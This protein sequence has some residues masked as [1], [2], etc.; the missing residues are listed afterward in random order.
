[1]DRIN[2]TPAYI[3]LGWALLLLSL[4]PMGSQFK[5]PT[6]ISGFWPELVIGELILVTLC[7][8]SM[9][10]TRKDFWAC[11]MTVLAFVIA[12]DAGIDLREVYLVQQTVERINSGP[13]QPKQVPTVHNNIRFNGYQYRA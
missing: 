6:G 3:A 1:M 10:R 13:D 4:L 2:R 5:G 11:V 8:W 7:C 12:V 9:D